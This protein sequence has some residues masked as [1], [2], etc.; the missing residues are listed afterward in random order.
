MKD[1]WAVG[2]ILHPSIFILAFALLGDARILLF[3]LNRVVFGSHRHEKNSW[4]WLL[5]VF[6]PLLLLLTL[7][8]G[9]GW[10]IVAAAIG[11]VWV[12]DRIRV[13]AFPQPPLTGVRTS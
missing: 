12:L 5:V 11:M 9:P 7:R 13:L 2:F 10:L 1:E 8:G 3:I 6:P 4:W